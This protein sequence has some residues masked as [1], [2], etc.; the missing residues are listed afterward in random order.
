MHAR[1]VSVISQQGNEIGPLMAQHSRPAT[2]TE[3]KKTGIYRC[4][5]GRGK[6]GALLEEEELGPLLCRAVGQ[7]QCPHC[8]GSGN[9]WSRKPGGPVT[10]EGTWGYRRGSTKEVTLIFSIIL[11]TG[12]WKT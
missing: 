6:V 1:T 7:E 3:L 2:V 5:P 4:W 11:R 8:E 12:P 10:G 9:L